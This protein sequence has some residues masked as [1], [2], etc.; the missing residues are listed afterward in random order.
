MPRSTA[1]SRPVD[2]NH[3]ENERTGD[4]NLAD[5]R[6]AFAL[7]L[8]FVA[9]REELELLSSG[10]LHDRATQHALRHANVKFF[11]DL[12]RALPAAEASTG[13]VASTGPRNTTSSSR[14]MSDV[15]VG[16]WSEGIGGVG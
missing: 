12:L 10:E 1:T 16:K 4:V 6:V 15:P 5:C 13:D 9:T 2:G 7:L 11:W 3:V 8:R 14:V